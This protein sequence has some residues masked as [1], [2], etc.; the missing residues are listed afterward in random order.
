MAEGAQ[1]HGQGSCGA[2]AHEGDVLGEERG[3]GDGIAAIR[4][5]A[6][7]GRR[8][9]QHKGQN[10][11]ARISLGAGGARGL[12]RHNAGLV[13]PDPA[14]GEGGYQDEDARG[15]ESL[16]PAEA[17]HQQGCH[18]GR[19]GNAHVAVDAVDSQGAAPGGHRPREQAGSGGMVEARPQAN[20]AKG[21]GQGPTGGS[22][23]GQTRRHPRH[24][25]P[26]QDH[27][28]SAEPVRRVARG[29]GAEAEEQVAAE[30]PGQGLF[31]GVDARGLGD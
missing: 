21:Q 9:Q 31:D 2:V 29:Q 20:A 10:R 28:A 17:L 13:N 16:P 3:L 23:G 27:P 4:K 24:H 6:Q 11:F 30:T 1:E 5:P 18:Q 7:G 8:A 22:G 26:G 15:Q 12:D 25:E 14:E 19:K